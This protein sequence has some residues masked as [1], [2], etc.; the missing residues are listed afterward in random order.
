MFPSP[1]NIPFFPLSSAAM[2]LFLL[3]LVW[4]CI[5]FYF[6]KKSLILREKILSGSHTI[7]SDIYEFV[8]CRR[9]FR[10]FPEDQTDIG[11][12]MEGQV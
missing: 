10:P 5:S 12:P 2:E 6:K 4:F 1:K 8:R 3:I 7:S 11:S 9:L